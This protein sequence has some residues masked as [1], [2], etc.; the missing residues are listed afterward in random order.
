MK[1]TL[2]LYPIAIEYLSDGML[3]EGNIYCFV[4]SK[5]VLM[6]TQGSYLTESALAKMKKADMT[7]RNV[8]VPE[9]FYQKLQNLGLPDS[10]H[11]EHLERAI[12]YDVAKQKIT[13]LIGDIA[14]TGT[15]SASQTKLV[16]NGILQ[17]LDSVAAALVLQ[18]I[19][20]KNKVD[21]YLYTHSTNVAFLNGLMAKW[22][23][24]SPE[25]ASLLIACG[26]M[27]DIG[28]VKIPN[29]ILYAPRK[30]SEQEFDVMKQHP[31]HSYEILQASPSI[32][33]SVALAALHHHEK[34]NGTG[35]PDRLSADH[36]PYYARITAVSDVYDAMVS[37]RSYK[38]AYSPFEIL[39]QLSEGKFS[40]LDFSLTQVFLSN[41]PLELIGR[42]V[43][44]S[45]GSI[46]IVRYVDPLNWLHPIVDVDGNVF[47]CDDT[48]SC[49]SVAFDALSY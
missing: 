31:V 41:M 8:Y 11:Q 40:D 48:M 47:A 2:G 23:K 6:V 44:L 24:L 29:D 30:L 25:E 27:H 4:D 17:K 9:A 5:P 34:M 38:N 3:A 33:P 20:G 15:V 21:E 49:V 19:N 16:S 10:L 7:F 42:S 22:L 28:K 18:C 45:N 43:L 14:Q 35:Y 32:H 46:G 36:I 26:L 39:E 37:K 1:H 13:K 12:G